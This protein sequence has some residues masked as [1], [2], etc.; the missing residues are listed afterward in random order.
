MVKLPKLSMS[1]EEEYWRVKR[2]LNLL[3]ELPE[4]LHKNI[5]RVH[6]AKGCL[7]VFV[8]SISKLDVDLICSAWSELGEDSNCVEFI[9]GDHE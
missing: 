8:K 1:R 5:S 7:E 9:M 6:D 3:A 2:L 4:Y